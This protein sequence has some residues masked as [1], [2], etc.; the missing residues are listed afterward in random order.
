MPFGPH[1]GAFMAVSGDAHGSIE[2]YPEGSG[3][4]IPSDD[5]Q[6]VFTDNEPPPG[7]WP[8]H[9]LLS[10]PLDVGKW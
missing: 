8:F 4:A 6:V 1:E 9:P 7:H 3:L 10:V 2:V 5:G